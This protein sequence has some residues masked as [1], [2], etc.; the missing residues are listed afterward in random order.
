M[1]AAVRLYTGDFLTDC[2]DDWC[3]TTRAY[4]RERCLHALEMLGGRLLARRQYRQAVEVLQQAV[5]LEP[6]RESLHRQLMRAHA[7][8]GERVQALRQFERCAQSL[9]S[10]FGVG[11]SRRT[12]RLH[13]QIRDEVPLD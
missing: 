1:L 8:A 10:E 12:R 7:L 6:V 3:L 9:R 13:Q 5:T 11:P 4:L 2:Y